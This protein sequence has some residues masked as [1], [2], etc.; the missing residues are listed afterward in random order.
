MS[1]PVNEPRGLDPTYARR[2]PPAPA[3]TDDTAETEQLNIA[4]PAPVKSSGRR[5]SAHRRRALTGSAA[6]LGVATT[7]G[8]AWTLT[9]G[10]SSQD[11]LGGAGSVAGDTG[12]DSDQ[13]GTDGQPAADLPPAGGE[14]PSNETGVAEGDQQSEAGS[15]GSSGSA[16]SGTGRSSNRPP[17]IESPGLASEGLVL[18]IEPNVNDPD[19][20]DVAL[21]YD[22]GGMEVCRTT[23]PCNVELDFADIG[24]QGDVAVTIIGTDSHGA[25]TRETYS[26]T[27]RAITDV[28]FADLGYAI[29]DAHACLGSLERRELTY[30]V[31]LDGAIVDVIDDSVGITAL[32]PTGFLP[33][34]RFASFEGEQPPPLSV[35]LQATLSDFRRTVFTASPYSS[36]E[37]VSVTIARD[38]P[39]EGVLTF[40][41]VFRTR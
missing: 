11:S 34:Q 25:T 13:P 30:R 27:V 8:L 28:H 7:V 23:E 41:V 31:H 9:G 21:L 29:N 39:C 16:S 35:S 12:L 19:G 10:D 6:A 26:H 24:Y 38:S 18:L 1:E 32:N 14:L 2:V 20:D 17:V 36:D 33:G 15:A 37:Q 3:G 4:K 22:V 40:S 5:G